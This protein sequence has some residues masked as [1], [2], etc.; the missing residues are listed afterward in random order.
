MKTVQEMKEDITLYDICTKDVISITLNATLQDAITL[1]HQNGL[2]D[3]VV[4]D[5]TTKKFG[6]L[7]VADIIKEE[8]STTPDLPLREIKLEP[9]IVESK[10]CYVKHVI[11]KHGL[12]FNY[13]CLIED[14]QLVGI[15]S[16]SDIITNYDPQLL[17]NF[18]RLIDLINYQKINY[19]P[20][21]MATKEAIMLLEEDIDDAIIIQKE[22][23][24][25]GIVTIRD[26]LKIF[27][28][29]QSLE[30]P[31][32]TYMSTPLQTL[33]K[34]A[35]VQDALK[36]LT[37]RHFK[38]AIIADESGKIL[39]IISQTE[40]TRLLYNKW[41]ELTRQSFDLAKKAVELEKI[42]MIDPLTHAYNRAQFEKTIEK[43]EERIRRYNTSFYSLILI[44]IDNFKK[45]N[46]TYG[47]DI[48]DSVL[49][50]FVANIQCYLRKNDILFRWGGEEFI[51]FLPQTSCQNAI[52]VAEKV[53]AIIEKQP[54]KGPGHVTCSFG[55]SAKR[56]IDDDVTSIIKRAD[57]ALYRA[58]QNGKNRVEAD[59]D[60]LL[61]GT[62]DY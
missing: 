14:D 53:R 39:G 1:M 31:I 54:F 29:N 34:E 49:K 33:P 9:C 24:S 7:T 47:H 48:G 10:N 50:G 42:A 59:C 52:I 4:I 37:Q 51:I 57:I 11:Q 41:L 20:H 13:I 62:T 55:V 58:K 25:V 23:K 16:K 38:R 30:K 60:T 32:S 44:D 40:L 2:R 26:V 19:V 8:A 12:G 17:A 21:D 6:I 22:G 35:T 56:A 43:E 28:N 18:E 5:E 3:V 45:V 27:A 61:T 15:V 36:F 46:D